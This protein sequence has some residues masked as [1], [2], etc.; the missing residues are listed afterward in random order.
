VNT[1]FWRN[2]KVLLTGHTGFKGSWLA[3]WMQHLGAHCL[4]YALN[5][6]TTPSLFNVLQLEHY[7]KSIEGN[8]NDINHITTVMQEFQPDIVL[9]LAAQALVADSYTDPINTYQTN[10]MGSLHVLEAIRKTPSVKA[11]IIVTSDKCYQNQEW[12]WG[13]R[14][15]ESLGGKDPYSS[16]KACTELLTASY[17]HSFLSHTS[18]ATVRA[19]NVIGGGDW[20]ANRLIPDLVRAC[21]KKSVVAIRH[22]EAIRPW[23]FIL[24]P[25]AGYMLLA[26]KSF[27]NLKHASAW[28][29][30][31]SEN[32]IKPVEYIANKVS[33]LWGNNT[34]WEKV[35]SSFAEAGLLKV[36]SSKAQV[37]LQWQPKLD[38]DQA[39]EW[40]IN[41]YKAYEANNNMRRYSI[42][43]IDTFMNINIKD[44]SK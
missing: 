39:L 22:P 4:G 21:V 44:T 34:V 16:S 26:E 10:V 36:D 19:G 2:K 27:N 1:E 8:I 35:A 42:N 28:N 38:L 6:A 33:A 9:H 11:S 30:G 23:Q 32:S 18:V 37:E 43:Q 15:N 29:F 12:H 41:W 31:P 17:R 24:E 3:L 7:I 25:L 40:T 20:S 5:P 14:E 13:Y